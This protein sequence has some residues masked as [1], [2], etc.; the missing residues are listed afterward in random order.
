MSRAKDGKKKCSICKA[1]LPATNEYFG[2]RKSAKDG[3]YSSC[4]SCSRNTGKDYNKRKG[5]IRNERKKP[6][7]AAYRKATRTF[8]LAYLHRHGCIDCGEKDP[9]VL[10]FDHV[11]GTKQ[12]NVSMMSGSGYSLGKIMEEISKCEVRCSN[13][14][15]K[16]TAV[17]LERYQHVDFSTLDDIDITN[18]EAFVATISSRTSIYPTPSANQCVPSSVSDDDLGR[19]D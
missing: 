8:L 17:Q 10:D 3:F 9:I 4:K 12:Y 16:R 19:P 14:H 18:P 2:F 6:Y 1:V 13:C 7:V 11:R 5:H 15:R